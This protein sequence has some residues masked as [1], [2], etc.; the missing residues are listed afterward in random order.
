MNA[1]FDT[2]SGN[3]AAQGGTDIDLLGD[4]TDSGVRGTGSVTATIVDDILGQGGTSTVSDFVSG[5]YSGGTAAAITAN[6]DLVTNNPGTG[7]L[8]GSNILSGNPELTTL[9]SYGGP[10]QTMALLPG[11][12]AIAAG[13][14]MAGISATNA[15]P[16]ARPAGRWTSGHSRIKGTSSPRLPVAA[17]DHDSRQPVCPMRWQ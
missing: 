3:T 17:A 10:T 12:P 16:R 14:G 2:F 15:W 9:G 1:T 8:T 11:S 13:A 4:S 5:T 7:G 6:N